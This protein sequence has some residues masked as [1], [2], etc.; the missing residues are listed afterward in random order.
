MPQLIATIS[1]AL[2]AAAD[3]AQIE[4]Q[5]LVVLMTADHQLL[6]NTLSDSETASLSE[7]ATSAG[8]NAGLG[9]M[10]DSVHVSVAGFS[11]IVLAGVG[12]ADALTGSK[13]QKLAGNLY[14]QLQKGRQQATILIDD[15]LTRQQFATFSLALLNAN[16]RFDDYK[17][18]K[19]DTS[20]THVAFIS[21]DDSLAD[22]L[23]FVTSVHQGQNLARFVGNQPGNVCFPA[24]MT[25]QAKALAAEFPD[26]LTVNVLG[27]AEMASLGMG[28]FLSVSKGSD[29]EG[30]LITLEYNATAH[31]DEQPVV[32]VGKGVTFDTGGISLKPGASMD[33]MKFD[34]CGS[35]SVLGTLRALC[36]AKLPIHVVGALACAE[37]MPSSG[38]T[39]PGDIVT[40]MS[41]QTV[42]ILNTDAEGRL[43]LCDTL[44]YIGKY[45]PAVVVDIATLTGACVIALGHVMTGLFSQDDELAEELLTASQTAHDRA[46]RM[47]LDD[48]YQELLDSSC[49]D[50]QNIGGRPAGS[51]TAACY[52]SRFTKDYRW[53]HL[54]IAGSAWVS[55]KNK[56]ATGRPVPMLMQFLRNRTQA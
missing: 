18:K 12:K 26:V 31:A 40:S 36:E 32:L 20:L 22:E 51:V 48:D 7:W 25:E 30:Q 8:F 34:M 52:L 46:W 9:E 49:A 21:S 14:K 6:G 2:A 16:Y 50:M 5:T 29:R 42:E 53:A 39:R 35:A 11:R 15:A 41:G 47:P 37:N 33:E 56:G 10:L 24:Y 44:T 38:A 54:D 45:N 13:L 43:V 4:Q 27:E 19:T 28:C 1:P 3:A 17:S 55:G 23:A